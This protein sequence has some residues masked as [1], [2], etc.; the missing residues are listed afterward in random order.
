MSKLGNFC[1]CQ[2]VYPSLLDLDKICFRFHEMQNKQEIW[3]I[4]N[5][6]ANFNNE[7]MFLLKCMAYKRWR[8]ALC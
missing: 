2:E 4:E 3:E 8:F 1:K 6:V 5:N 7:V